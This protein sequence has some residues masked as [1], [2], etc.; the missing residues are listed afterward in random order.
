[1]KNALTTP[2][3]MS[4]S[5]TS[6][7]RTSGLISN[8]LLNLSPSCIAKPN[9]N[10]T[11][12]S[13]KTAIPQPWLCC[14]HFSPLFQTL[15]SHYPPNLQRQT[16]WQRF[17]QRFIWPNGTVLGWEFNLRIKL[18]QALDFDPRLVKNIKKTQIP[19]KKGL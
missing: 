17:I 7:V 4:A 18:S 1:M 14:S 13:M 16:D 6:A 8:R 12:K 10:Y 5:S 15:R 3:I 19:N 2:Q 9:H 11:P